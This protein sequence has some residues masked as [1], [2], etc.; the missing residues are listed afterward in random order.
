MSC[1]LGGAK[2]GGVVARLGGVSRMLLRAMVGGALQAGGLRVSHA[3]PPQTH[4]NQNMTQP[5]KINQKA[6]TKTN[7][8]TKTQ[9]PTSTAR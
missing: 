2:A 1:L 8:T 3:V 6:Q 4:P 5:T 7:Q 9:N